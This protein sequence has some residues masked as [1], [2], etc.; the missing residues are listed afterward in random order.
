[1][2]C[3]ECRSRSFGHFWHGIEFHHRLMIELGD[4]HAAMWLEGQKAVDFEPAQRLAYRGSADLQ[5]V[6][7]LLFAHAAAGSKFSSLD[8]FAKLTIGELAERDVMVTVEF[9]G[10]DIRCGDAHFTLSL[11]RSKTPRGACGTGLFLF[12]NH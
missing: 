12:P 5:P 8:R 6:G 9:G 3:R 4:Y 2:R 11:C 10:R 7:N 1:M